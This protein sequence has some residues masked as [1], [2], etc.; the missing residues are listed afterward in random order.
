MANSPYPLHSSR[1]PDRIV[2]D[3]LGL[4]DFH[5]HDEVLSVEALR[6]QTIGHSIYILHSWVCDKFGLVVTHI[7]ASSSSL[8]KESSSCQ[9]TNNS[10][11]TSSTNSSSNSSHSSVTFRD[12]S[13]PAQL[14]ATPLSR[15]HLMFTFGKLFFSSSKDVEDSSRLPAVATQ[16]LRQK[17][18]RRLCQDDRRSQTRTTGGIHVQ[19]LT[20]MAHHVT[21]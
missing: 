12:H 15:K 13:P 11:P 3:V 9:S 20:A 21:R 10:L 7:N 19:L 2:I 1:E 17:P 14:L 8:S 4:Q 16:A 6:S 5:W 18:S